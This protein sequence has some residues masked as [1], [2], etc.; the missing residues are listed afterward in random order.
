MGRWISTLLLLCCACVVQAERM[1]VIELQG[2]LPEQVVPLIQ[3]VLQPGETVKVFRG[4]L[5]VVASEASFQRINELLAEVD[6]PPRN[7]L[8]QVSDAA[9][10]TSRDRSTTISGSVGSDDARLHVNERPRPGDDDHVRVTMNDSNSTVNA[11]IQ[12]QVRAVEGYPAFIAQSQQA[13]VAAVDAYGRPL[14][15]AQTATQGFFVT[16]RL[17][18]SQVFLDISTSHD[19]LS[20]ARLNTRR[21]STTVSGR[22]GDWIDI[23]GTSMRASQQGSGIGQRS[24]SGVTGSNNLSLRVSLT[25]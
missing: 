13:P 8:I 23:S 5:V 12:Q 16:V 11:D 9:Q 3:Q 19:S 2:A 6:R 21:T 20:D 22:L 15:V 14:A 17:Q 18:G 24:S 25:D 4:Q 7:V 1:E 10:A